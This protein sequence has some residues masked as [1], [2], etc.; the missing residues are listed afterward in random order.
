[1]AVLSFPVV[2]SAVPGP[3]LLAPALCH[4]WHGSTE[5]EQGTREEVIC[6]VNQ[7][8]VDV[9]SPA[10]AIQMFVTSLY[11]RPRA[12]CAVTSFSGAMC[13]V[14]EASFPGCNPAPCLIY[15]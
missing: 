2:N 13:L 3:L 15:F 1:M 5:P 8:C 14:L 4:P 11:P 6:L 10:L 12:R 9:A 7:G